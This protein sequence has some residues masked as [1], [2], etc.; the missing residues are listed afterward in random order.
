MRETTR[1]RRKVPVFIA[2]LIVLALAIAACGGS[3]GSNGSPGDNTDT[4][5]ETDGGK[6]VYGGTITYSLEAKTT[7]FCPPAGQW[8]IS[9]IVA[10]SSLYD[11]LTR[12]TDDPDVL[13]YLRSIK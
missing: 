8:A 11:T 4:P 1:A 10:A 13:A 12:P 5:S 2:L 3:S 6:P 9:A 7:A